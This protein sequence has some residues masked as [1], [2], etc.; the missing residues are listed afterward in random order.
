MAM[1][2]PL[3]PENPSVHTLEVTVD[4]GRRLAVKESHLSRGCIPLAPLTPILSS[5]IPAELYG[6]IWNIHLVPKLYLAKTKYL[7]YVKLYTHNCISI[8]SEYLARYIH[9]TSI[10]IT[11]RVYTFQCSHWA[12]AR[13]LRP[14]ALNE[15]DG[16]RTRPRIHGEFG[17]MDGLKTEMDLKSVK[18]S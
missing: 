16:W 13:P 2:I 10:C 11:M 17:G 12:K 7:I 18:I 1:A 9:C 14:G 3:H 15:D 5:H 4:K 8:Y 6:N